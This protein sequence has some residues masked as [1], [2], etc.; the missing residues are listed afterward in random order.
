MITVCPLYRNILYVDWTITFN[1]EATCTQRCDWILPQCYEDLLV[2]MW[3]GY[4]YVKCPFPWSYFL[5]AVS[6]RALGI[7]VIFT[8]MNDVPVVPQALRM[9]SKS[10]IKSSSLISFTFLFYLSCLA[11]CLLWQITI[12]IFCN[13]ISW[14]NVFCTM[15]FEQFLEKSTHKGIPLNIT[16]SGV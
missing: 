12:I 1:I 8:L 13:L 11:L 16:V 14:E 3:T 7:C 2:R 15:W 4:N 10:E 5:I 9:K 6:S